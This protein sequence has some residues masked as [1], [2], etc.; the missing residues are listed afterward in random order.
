MVAELSRD[1]FLQ[2]IQ[3]MDLQ[4]GEWLT[5]CLVITESLHELNIPDSEV[6]EVIE[7]GRQAFLGFQEGFFVRMGWTE[8]IACIKDE[9]ENAIMLVDKKISEITLK[10]KH[11]GLWKY[12]IAKVAGNPSHKIWEVEW[13]TN[14]GV[15]YKD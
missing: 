6:D 4:A 1:E 3:F 10:N 9:K 8:Y 11:C 12:N 13:K 14:K 2:K 15:H 5:V 7:L